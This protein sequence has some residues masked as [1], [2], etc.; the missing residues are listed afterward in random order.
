V[1][2]IYR[3][4]MVENCQACP[5][6]NR[7]RNVGR[8]CDL[9]AETLRHFDNIK[10]LNVYPKR[11]PLFVEGQ[12]P[13]GVFLLCQGRVSMS[14]AAPD[15]KT[16]IV[17]IAQ[18]GEVLGLSAVLSGEPYELSAQTITSCLVASVERADFLHFLK[19]FPDACLAAAEQLSEQYHR[20]CQ[21]LRNLRLPHADQRLAK[22]LLEWDL[23]HRREGGN[24]DRIEMPMTRE[25]IA[26][27]IGTT[28]ETVV[29]AF[30]AFKHKQ[31]IEI[32]GSE[33]LIR[34]RSGLMNIAARG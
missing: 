22:W 31:L 23:Q 21:Q 19:E 7:S 27:F 28:R 1:L 18:P 5:A 14:V 24:G 20:A 9:T 16:L 3:Q 32:H 13:R 17:K 15:G 4:T 2:A 26:Q 8:F 6:R 29:R 10:V 34:S 30:A 12:S 33:I 11:V 25:C